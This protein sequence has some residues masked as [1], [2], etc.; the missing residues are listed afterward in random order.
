M[1]LKKWT[2]LIGKSFIDLNEQQEGPRDIL[3]IFIFTKQF[4]GDTTEEHFDFVTF[5]PQLGISWMRM[6]GPESTIV[7]RFLEGHKIIGPAKHSVQRIGGGPI[8]CYEHG[9]EI[10]RIGSLMKGDH[11]CIECHAEI[12][13]YRRWIKKITKESGGKP[14]SRRK[15]SPYKKR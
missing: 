2:D 8:M 15:R 6:P 14:K 10:P 12:L 3:Q 9:R 4:K 1:P 13:K 5:T 11:P 7:S